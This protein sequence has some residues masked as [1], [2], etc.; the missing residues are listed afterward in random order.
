[1]KYLYVSLLAT[2]LSIATLQGKPEIDPLL[3]CCVYWIA[4]FLVVNDFK[5]N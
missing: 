1:M 5:K 2:I 4:C 3:Y